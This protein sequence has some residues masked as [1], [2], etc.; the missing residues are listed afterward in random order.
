MHTSTVISSELPD[1]EAVCCPLLASLKGLSDLVVIDEATAFRMPASE[2]NSRAAGILRA[3]LAQTSVD[4]LALCRSLASA[5]TSKFRLG[6]Q[7]ADNFALT[8]TS[9]AQEASLTPKPV[10]SF[11]TYSRN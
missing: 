9:M 1:V 5:E 10:R 7:P 6:F 11:V 3:M 8:H 4:L 2:S